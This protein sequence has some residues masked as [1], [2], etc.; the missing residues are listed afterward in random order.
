MAAAKEI[1]EAILG[2]MS[3]IFGRPNAAKTD[4]EVEAFHAE[5][6]AALAPYSAATLR[7]AWLRIR[8]THDRR[9]W[10]TIAEIRAACVAPPSGSGLSRPGHRW[11][12]DDARA[13]L[14]R[15]DRQAQRFVH[16]AQARAWHKLGPQG[17]VR[18]LFWIQRAERIPTL[19]Q[20]ARIATLSSA[21]I[22]RELAFAA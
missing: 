21:D 6:L 13:F 1:F 10:P 16:E 8:D 22:S 19:A 12:L 9:S 7:G 18:V 15:F 14:E 3:S 2:P 4:A 11:R 20:I 5:Y 17:R